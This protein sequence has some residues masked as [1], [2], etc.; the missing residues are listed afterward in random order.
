MK[1]DPLIDEIRRTR[2]AISSEFKHDS[3]KYIE[4][5]QKFEQKL[6]A[7][8]EYHFAGSVA[9]PVRKSHRVVA[10]ARVRKEKPSAKGNGAI[11]SRQNHSKR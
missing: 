7:S 6:R 5:L 11:R 2:H 9:R 4:H 3:A 10:K 8:G 1:T